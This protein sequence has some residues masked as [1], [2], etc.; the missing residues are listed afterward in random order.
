MIE[1]WISRKVRKEEERDIMADPSFRKEREMSME[2]KSTAHIS[3]IK[4]K[5][6]RCE[7]PADRKEEKEIRFG[8]RMDSSLEE[9]SCW[10]LMKT[11][12]R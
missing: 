4:G 11:G 9:R 2:E 7:L 8:Q 5:K 10:Q 3:Q 12:M 6:K 1:D